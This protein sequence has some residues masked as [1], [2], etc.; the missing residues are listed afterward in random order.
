MTSK[1]IT[2]KAE[3]YFNEVIS[4]YIVFIWQLFDFLLHLEHWRCSQIRNRTLKIH[5][6]DDTRDKC[7]KMFVS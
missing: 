1:Y 2:I 7:I 5:L 3:L 6:Q 4:F